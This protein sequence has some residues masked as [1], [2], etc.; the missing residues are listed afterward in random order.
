MAADKRY[1]LKSA[2]VRVNVQCVCYNIN[3]THTMSVGID[4]LVNVG[5]PDVDGYK[6][7][8]NKIR[9]CLSVASR[10]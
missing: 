1:V 7:M 3:K 9:I 8:I 4:D 6:I 10:V 5:M 2:G